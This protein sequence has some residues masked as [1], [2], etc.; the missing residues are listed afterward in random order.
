MI[1]ETV[2]HRIADF[3]SADD[4]FLDLPATGKAELFNFIGRHMEKSRGISSTMVARSLARREQI[5]STGLGRGVAIPH[6]RIERLDRTLGCYARLRT[7]IPFQAP[8]GKPVIDVLTLLV[9]SP[10]TD[11][12]LLVLAE[13]TQLF[14]SRRFRDAVHACS[15][16]GEVLRL[17]SSWHAGE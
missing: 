7:P 8:D 12:H 16:N 5:G 9:P 4:I 3:L 10:S 1:A 14:V 6:A 11:E 13:A 17:F 2:S 15:D